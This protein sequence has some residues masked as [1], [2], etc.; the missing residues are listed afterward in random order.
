MDAR[1]IKFDSVINIIK[2]TFRLTSSE[3]FSDDLDVLKN[4][5]SN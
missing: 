2:A 1:V 3:V 4:F 5:R